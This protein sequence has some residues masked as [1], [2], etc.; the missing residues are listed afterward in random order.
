MKVDEELGFNELL[1]VQFGPSQRKL[2]LWEKAESVTL[3]EALGGHKD[4]P[5]CLM[6]G[7]EGGFSDDE[8]VLAQNSGW[9]PVSLGDL[10]LRA[11][12]AAIAAVV[13]TNHLL[14]RM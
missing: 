7:P 10:I 2:I 14:G 3:A 13:V 4:A 5:V 1:A 12:T 6:I 8:A 11:E 9:L